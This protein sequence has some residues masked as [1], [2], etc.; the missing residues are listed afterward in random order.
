ME[1]SMRLFSRNRLLPA[2]F[3]LIGANA[4]SATTVFNVLDYGAHNDGSAPATDA[5]RSA[6][7]AAK[8]AGGGTAY[9]PA[10]KYVTGPIELVSNLVLHIDAGATLS[11][12]AAK[13]PFAKGR[14]Q[15]IECLMPI[16]LIGGTNVDEG[17]RRVGRSGIDSMGN[18]GGENESSKRTRHRG[19]Q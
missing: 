13:L 1:T 5:I 17:A 14:A 10:G 2:L 18:Q 12:P 3:L 11:F 19:C 6:I 8:A 7:Q 4:W 9:F 15:G 16:P